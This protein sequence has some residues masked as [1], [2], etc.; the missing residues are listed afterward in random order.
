MTAITDDRNLRAKGDEA[1]SALGGANRHLFELG[2]DGRL[3]ALESRNVGGIF[4]LSVEVLVAAI[5]EL[6]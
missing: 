6:G 1:D 3:D 2:L 5:S 4:S